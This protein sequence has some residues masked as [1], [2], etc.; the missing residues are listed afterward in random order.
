MCLRVVI[1]VST[2]ITPYEDTTVGKNNEEPE[3]MICRKGQTGVQ[4]TFLSHP[5]LV[6]VPPGP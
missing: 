1:Y 6:I 5:I 3:Y 2:Y 4:H